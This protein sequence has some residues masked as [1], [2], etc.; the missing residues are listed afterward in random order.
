MINDINSVSAISAAHAR[1]VKAAV[2]EDERLKSVCQDFEALFIEQILKS[3]RS[4]EIDSVRQ[5]SLSSS[6]LRISRIRHGWNSTLTSREDHC[7]RLQ[8]PS[9]S[10][11]FSVGKWVEPVNI[12]RLSFG[13]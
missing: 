4:S 3:S 8:L 1:S 12:T 5:V 10:A 11:S 13:N 2:S 7:S 6:K 9:L